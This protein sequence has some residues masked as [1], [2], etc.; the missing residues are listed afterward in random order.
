[1]LKYDDLRRY[2]HPGSYID[3]CDVAVLILDKPFDFDEYVRPVCLPTIDWTS[4]LSEGTMIASGMG[5]IGNDIRTS[6]LKLA[7]IQML[8]KNKCKVIEFPG[9]LFKGT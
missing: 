2:K 5:R 1:M 7:S 4:R 3:G 8:S 6:E 9:S